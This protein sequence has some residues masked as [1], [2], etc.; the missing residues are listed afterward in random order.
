MRIFLLIALLFASPAFGQILNQ[1]E[2]VLEQIVPESFPL[3]GSAVTTHSVIRSVTSVSYTLANK[4]GM[5]LYLAMQQ[6]GVSFGTCGQIDNVQGGL[7]RVPQPHALFYSAP[8]GGG[9]PRGVFVPASGQITGLIVFDDCGAPNP[10]VATAS[11]SLTLMV[12]KTDDWNR[13]S[14]IPLSAVLPVRLGPGG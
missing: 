13:M 6:G 14:S 7:P 4:T 10:D 3:S 1:N 2:G 11:F 5:N 12:G 8:M 9:K